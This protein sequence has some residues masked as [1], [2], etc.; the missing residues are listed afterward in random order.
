MLTKKIKL[1]G[2]EIE[3]YFEDRADFAVNLTWILIVVKLI[4]IYFFLIN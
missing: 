3:F 4:E 1:F 2:K